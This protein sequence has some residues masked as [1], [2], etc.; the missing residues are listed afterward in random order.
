[1]RRPLIAALALMLALG[2]CG[3]IRESR[4]NPLNWF[5]GSEEQ[6]VAAG[7]VAPRDPRPLVDQ[8]SA[9]AVDRVIGGAIVRA[10]GVPATQGFWNAELVR[11]EDETL[12]PDTIVFDFRVVPPPYRAEAGTQ[13]SREIEAGVALTDN[14]LAGV[15]RIVVRG[16]R[17]ER[18]VRR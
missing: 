16:A 14:D 12:D 11:V 4:F 5:G 2:A 9:M 13:P 15:S 17:T 3:A 18:V 6:T 8:V 10:T 1:M 7:F